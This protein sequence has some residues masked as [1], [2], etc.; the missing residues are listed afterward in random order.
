[1]LIISSSQYSQNISLGISYKVITSFTLDNNS[2]SD[3]GL[4]V[5]YGG[6]IGIQFQQPFPFISG[7]QGYYG[8]KN[9]Y[10]YQPNIN[11]NLPEGTGSL[12]GSKIDIELV[13]FEIPFLY[14]IHNTNLLSLDIGIRL[15]LGRLKRLDNINFIDENTGEIFRSENYSMSNT[16]FYY[17]PTLEISMVPISEISLNLGIEYL[18]YKPTLTYEST[19]LSTSYVDPSVKTRDQIKYNINSGEYVIKYNM[20]GLQFRISLN[21]LL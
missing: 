10:N 8:K 21:Y 6:R 3:Y 2:D 16:Q 17:S 20:N 12:F 4:F 11:P 19:S 7:I 1:M 14:R 9:I 15:G 13:S 18:F 5:G